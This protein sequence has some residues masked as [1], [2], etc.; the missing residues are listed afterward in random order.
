MR[1]I[2]V[3]PDYCSSGLWEGNINLFE[4]NF[5]SV[6]TFTDLMALRYWHHMWE[7]YADDGTPKGERKLS[8]LYWDNWSQHGQALVDAWN[9]KQ[10]EFLFVY[11]GDYWK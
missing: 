10:N 8:E 9:A 5:S 4:E 6:L 1:V 11:E 3:L 7:L 2:K